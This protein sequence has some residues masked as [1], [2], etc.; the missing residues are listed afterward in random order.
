MFLVFH[1]VHTCPSASPSLAGAPE[2][3]ACEGPGHG[4]HLHVPL[5]AH[6][7]HHAPLD[8]PAAGA[9][10]GDPHLVVARQ[11]VQLPLQ[12]PGVGGQLLPAHEKGTR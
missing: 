9:T 6:G 7:V 1:E 3:R 8:G 12:L 10:D 11:A 4:T 2:P 5:L